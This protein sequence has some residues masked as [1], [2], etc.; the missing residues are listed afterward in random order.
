MKPTVDIVRAAG[1]VVLREVDGKTQVVVVHRPRYND[2]SLPKGKSEAGETDEETAVRE[3][4]EETGWRAEIESTLPS[5]EYTDQK[6]RPKIVIWFLMRATVE[7][8]FTP[9]E[10]VDEVRWLPFDEADQLLTYGMDRDLLSGV[11][12]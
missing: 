8:G 4:E 6:G 10:E 12:S 2:W 11:V 7:S 9:D 5:F 1:G 3:V